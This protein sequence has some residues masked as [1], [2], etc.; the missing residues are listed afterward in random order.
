MKV[1]LLSSLA[2]RL[3][4]LH[5]LAEVVRGLEA[6]VHRGEA[7]VGDLVEPRQL[8]HHEVAHAAGR[9]LALAERAQ[10]L[11]HAVD[12][13]LDL[14]GRH[15]PLAQGEP[16]A[17]GDL[18]AVEIGAA[19]V[20]LHQARHFQ[21][22]ALVGREALLALQAFAPPPDGVRLGICAGVDDLGV[23]RGA[24]GAFHAYT[25]KRAHSARISS[26]TRFTVASLAGCS[27]TSA[28]SRASSTASFSLK[29][30]VVIAG[31]PMRIPEVT[32]GF[33]GSFG[34][35]F[36][37]T[38]M[39]ARPSTSSASRP[40]MRFARR[41]TRNRWHSVRPETMRR[42]RACSVCAI[43]RAFFNTCAWYSRNSGLSASPSA[44]ALAAMTC[45]SGPPWMPGKIAEL[46]ARSCS[47]SA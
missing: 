19:A 30:R 40:V 10:P 22:D 27:S 11:D 24:E 1:A 35:A 15:R 45:I 4:F 36:L 44:T 25:G 26:P 28:M 31:E 20:L 41:S 7:D 21:V 13:A 34:I 47:A 18:V 38:V 12:R 6:A 5:R 32:I 42:P 33:S 14:V 2:R 3:D 8:A 9:H 16:H 46:S 43:A 17:A 29:P 23:L 37:F 39:C